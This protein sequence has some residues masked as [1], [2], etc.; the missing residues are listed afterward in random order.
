MPEDCAAGDVDAA[1]ARVAE[2][3]NL[4]VGLIDVEVIELEDNVEELVVEIVLELVDVAVFWAWEAR[5]D[6]TSA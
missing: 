2:L 5:M 6:V 3:V 4:D 1:P